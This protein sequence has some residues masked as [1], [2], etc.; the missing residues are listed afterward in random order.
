MMK[1]METFQLSR[2]N[3]SPE[4]MISPDMREREDFEES[5]YHKTRFPRTVYSDIV[6]YSDIVTYSSLSS[7]ISIVRR[8]R[9]RLPTTRSRLVLYILRRPECVGE[10]V[11]LFVMVIP[12]N[13]RPCG[14]IKVIY[15]PL[16]P[17][18]PHLFFSRQHLS[19][20]RA[21]FC[22]VMNSIY[23]IILKVTNCENDQVSRGPLYSLR[24]YKYQL[25]STCP[26]AS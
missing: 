1:G 4:P 16:S 25:L 12:R 5:F 10:H 3:S 7:F 26:Q 23:F 14:V 22:M 20:H 2:S 9:T 18:P 13:Q 21:F 11:P 19:T 15:S 6:I 24:V 17:L 8:P